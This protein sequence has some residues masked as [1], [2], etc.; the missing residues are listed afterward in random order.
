MTHTLIVQTQN[1]RQ[2]LV[3]KYA[4]KKEALS[5]AS[6]AIERGYIQANDFYC[7]LGQGCILHVESDPPLIPDPSTPPPV[8]STYVVASM[9]GGRFTVGFSTELEATNAILRAVKTGVFEQS[10]NNGEETLFIYAEP[11]A[12]Y[13][14]LTAEVYAKAQEAAEPPPKSRVTLD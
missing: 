10:F 14:K 5:V 9:Y 1:N 8:H 2:T 4:S 13:M 12:C 3:L 7:T 11:G 6:Q